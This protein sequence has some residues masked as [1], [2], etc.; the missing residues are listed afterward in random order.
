M[1][2]SVVECRF[3]VTDAE[4]IALVNTLCVRGSVID[5]LFF[6]DDFGVLLSLCFRL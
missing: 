1:Y 4:V 6:L 5:D 3:D 2:E